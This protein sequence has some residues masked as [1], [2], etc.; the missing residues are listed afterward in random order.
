MR[1]ERVV[2]FCYMCFFLGRACDGHDGRV[3]VSRLRATATAL[4][5]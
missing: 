4:Y 2:I 3:Y 5:I 1:D